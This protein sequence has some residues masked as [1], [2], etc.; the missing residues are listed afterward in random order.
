MRADSGLCPHP[1]VSLF[2]ASYFT[3]AMFLMY[4]SFMKELYGIH[5]DA[6]SCIFAFPPVVYTL[7]ARFDYFCVMD[8]E[9]TCD[10]VNELIRYVDS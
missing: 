10:T 5:V 2:K 7:F 6:Q 4:L 8:F 3:Y 9:C 1:P